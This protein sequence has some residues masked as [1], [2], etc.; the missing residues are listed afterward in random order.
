MPAIAP[1]KNINTKNSG[2]VSSHLSSIHPMKAPTLILP[3]LHLFDAA[4]DI[5]QAFIAVWILI[6]HLDC[7]V[8]GRFLSMKSTP[9]RWE[10]NN[11]FACPICCTSKVRWLVTDWPKPSCF[12]CRKRAQHRGGDRPL[13]SV[14]WALSGILAQPCYDDMGCGFRRRNIIGEIHP[15]PA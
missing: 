6:G 12:P 3:R 14:Q 13:S 7:P 2:D 10:K 1:R 15:K 8:A 11:G 4:L 5:C 9:W